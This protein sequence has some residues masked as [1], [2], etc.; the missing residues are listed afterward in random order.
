MVA[1][2]ISIIIPT[3]NALPYFKRAVHSL[4]INTPNDYELIVVDNGSRPDMVHYI[5]SLGCKAIFN[6]TNLGPGV[7]F[8][9]GIRISDGEYI[10]LLNSDADVS[11]NWLNYMLITLNRDSSIGIVGP[12]CDNISS[13]QSD[14]KLWGG[15]DYVVPKYHVMPFVCVLMKREIFKT[16]GL[17]A[18]RFSGGCSEDSEF[19]IRLENYGYIKMVAAKAFVHHH[20]NQSYRDNNVDAAAICAEMN[21]VHLQETEEIQYLS[22]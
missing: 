15:D 5:K 6:S 18:E 22:E 12:T 10:C 1:N 17:I 7:A 16:V 3:W 19:C 21:R 8:N 20:L 11:N 14:R 4:K 9:Q 2:K 13:L